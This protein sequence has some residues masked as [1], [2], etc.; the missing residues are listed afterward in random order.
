[1]KLHGYRPPPELL[2]LLPAETGKKNI[3]EKI[4]V[5]HPDYPKVS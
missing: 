2:R 5:N 1:M 3:G 4:G